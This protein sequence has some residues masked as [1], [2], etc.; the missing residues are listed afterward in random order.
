MLCKFQKHLGALLHNGQ[1]WHFASLLVHLEHLNCCTARRASIRGNEHD[2]V[3]GNSSSKRRENSKRTMLAFSITLLL[4]KLL[5]LSSR[6]PSGFIPPPTLDGAIY[7]LTTTTTTTILLFFYSFIYLVDL[8]RTH[9]TPF[10][11]C[12]APTSMFIVIR[13]PPIPRW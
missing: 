12:G 5:R 6:S 11:S 4:P 2:S 7:L 10:G 1:E 3:G 9:K 8:A 13:A